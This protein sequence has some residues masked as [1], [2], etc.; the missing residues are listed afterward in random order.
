MLLVLMVILRIA[1]AVGIRGVDVLEVTNTIDGI[2]ERGVNDT[3]R[4][5]LL[6]L[7]RLRDAIA[8]GDIDSCRYY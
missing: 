4:L 7:L 1:F 8:G 3:K 6:I 2:A 5:V